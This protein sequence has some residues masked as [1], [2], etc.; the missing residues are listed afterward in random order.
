[1]DYLRQNGDVGERNPEA[2]E[3]RSDHHEFCFLRE[4]LKR[5]KEYIPDQIE[6][7][8]YYYRIGSSK[9]P[10]QERSEGRDDYC[11]YTRNEVSHCNEAF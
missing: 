5:P 2:R 1:M 6:R 11:P 9:L 10:H 4:E 8:P 7:G 3:G